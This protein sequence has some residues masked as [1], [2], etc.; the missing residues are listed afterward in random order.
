[1][2]IL[3]LQ[4]CAKEICRSRRE[5]S[6]EYLVTKI[7]FDTAENEPCKVCLCKES[8]DTRSA[9]QTSISVRDL[10]ARLWML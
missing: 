1:M 9:V 8:T 5:L 7:G 10:E 2:K 3:R 6:N 4:S